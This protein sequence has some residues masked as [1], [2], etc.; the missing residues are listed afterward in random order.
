MTDASFGTR[1]R[2]GKF[3]VPVL[4]TIVA[5]AVVASAAAMTV[6]TD[7][8]S[9]TWTASTNWQGSGAVSTTSASPCAVTTAVQLSYLYGG[10]WYFRSYVYGSTY[11]SDAVTLPVSEVFSRHQ[12]G[13]A[14]FGWGQEEYTWVP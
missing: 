6:N 13:V 1:S 7:S 9:C 12:I 5:L 14:G 8:W 3:M 11:T 4:A 10:S 2:G